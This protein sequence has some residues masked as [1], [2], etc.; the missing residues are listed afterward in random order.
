MLQ[1]VAAAHRELSDRQLEREEE[2][3][4]E[5]RWGRSFSCHCTYGGSYSVTGSWRERRSGET[6]QSRVTVYLWGQLLT[7]RQLKEEVRWGRSISCH[8]TYGGSCSLTGSWRERRSGEAGQAR[9]IVSAAGERAGQRMRKKIKYFKRYRYYFCPFFLY[10]LSTT[11]A[12]VGAKSLAPESD[13]QHWFDIV[14]IL[15]MKNKK[16]SVSLEQLNRWLILRPIGTEPSFWAIAGA[17][18][19]GRLRLRL[20]IWISKIKITSRHFS[21]NVALKQRSQIH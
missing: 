14:L 1:A 2:E 6:G 4:E 11:E 19:S 5:V 20:R 15:H 16:N 3:D 8:C 17:H 7:D 18:F 13:P 10:I 9:V 12:E 21:A